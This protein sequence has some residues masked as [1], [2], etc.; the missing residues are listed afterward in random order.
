MSTTTQNFIG[1]DWVD[2]SSEMLREVIEPSTGR[3]CGTMTLSTA[4]D[5]DQAVRS[6][7]KAF[8]IFA[9]TSAEFRRQ[10]LERIISGFKRR[11]EDLAVSM[12][13]EMGAPISMSRQ[14]QIGAGLS[15]LEKTYALLEHF[16]FETVKDGY[17]LRYE[18]IGVVAM[19]TP[20]NWPL[21]QIT[22]KVASALAGGNTMVLK[23]SEECPTC[24]A[25]F[26]E[27]MQD[28]G[29]P[30]GVFNLIQG[31]AKSGEALASHPL[32]DMV[33]ITGSTRAGIAVAHAAA[34]TVKRVHQE[35]GGN[36]ANIVLPDS[37][38]ETI[39]PNA[40]VGVIVNSGQSCITPTRLLVHSNDVPRTEELVAKHLSAVSVG[41]A[42]QEGHHIGPLVNQK[43]AAH[44]KG[45]ISRAIE[46]GATLL[47]GGSEPPAGFEAGF[48]V[49]PTAFS[50]VTND[51]E[52]ARA[53][54]FGP[55]VTIIAYDDVDQAVRIANDTEYGLSAVVSGDP[56]QAAPLTRKLRAGSVLINGW[57]PDGSAPFGGY[58]QSGNGREL[59]EEGLRDF[60][61]IKAIFGLPTR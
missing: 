18:P 23:P 9:D 12:S 36:A 30:A 13:R 1:G 58:K 11:S 15:N 16:Q 57:A 35:L 50:G 32:V 47:C 41:V 48:F 17:V 24:A 7:A 60:M 25:I 28:A 29:T 59:V 45:L 3:A 39:V 33:S 4:S 54:I 46:D 37:D 43:Q 5:V 21:N 14:A 27:V 31:D 53:E 49:Q 55:V 44:V 10:L 56:Q 8:E 42:D 38:L 6:A 34:N 22:A 2:S 20:W 26:A 52:I 61:E 40:L 51:M 19:I